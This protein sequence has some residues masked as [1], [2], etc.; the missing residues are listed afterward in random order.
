MNPFFAVGRDGT[1]EGME[2]AAG[3]RDDP[4]AVPE[5]VDAYPEASMFGL[6]PAYGFYIRHARGIEI[7]NVAIRLIDDDERPTFVVEDVA[8][9]DVRGLTV[10]RSGGEPIFVLRDVSDFRVALSDPVGDIQLDHVENH[11]IPDP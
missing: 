1:G 2:D 11:R 6:L 7:D 4:Y 5:R 10:H 8:A 3:S 9:I